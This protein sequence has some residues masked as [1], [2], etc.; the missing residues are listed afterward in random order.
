[1]TSDASNTKNLPPDSATVNAHIATAYALLAIDDTLRSSLDRISDEQAET[2]MG[3]HGECCEPAPAGDLPGKPVEPGDLRAGDRVAFAWV[4]TGERIT[5]ALR[6]SVGG[7]VLSSDTPL[8]SDYRPN[9]VAGGEWCYEIFDVRLIERAP[10][11]DEDPN[12]AL[13]RVIFGD[14]FGSHEGLRLA[15]LDVAR[16]AREFI[17]AEADDADFSAADLY[18]ARA[19]KAEAERDEW[20]EVAARY[21]D[22][23]D[24]WQARHA[25]LRADVEA[26][27]NASQIEGIL[28][29]DDE[30]AAKGEGR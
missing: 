8:S 14:A 11:E 21:A 9:V 28:A 24:K 22:W 18:Y 30:R 17:E 13:A 15:Q 20:R 6:Q 4:G 26:C 12:E 7:S 29:R 25:A 1:M 19:T 16:A 27:R 23:R 10:R 3:G 5:C 2:P